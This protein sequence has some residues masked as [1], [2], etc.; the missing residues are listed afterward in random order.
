MRQEFFWYTNAN[1]TPIL[2]A[3]VRR[4]NVQPAL[5]LREKINIQG[6][7]RNNQTVFKQ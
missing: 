4:K 2:H 6:W 5:V 7:Y 3:R 1:Q